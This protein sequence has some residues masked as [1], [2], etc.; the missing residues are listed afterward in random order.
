MKKLFVAFMLAMLLASCSVLRYSSN[1]LDDIPKT[2]KIQHDVMEQVLENYYIMGVIDYRS[3]V[4][5]GITPV[6]VK[7]IDGYY[8]ERL[9]RSNKELYKSLKKILE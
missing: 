8:L 7:N 2:M 4:E 5:D 9:K 1:D 6:V 3:T